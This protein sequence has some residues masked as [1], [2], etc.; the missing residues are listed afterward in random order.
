MQEEN[1]IDTEISAIV[2]KPKTLEKIVNALLSNSFAMHDIHIQETPEE[3][4]KVVG[5]KY[6]DPKQLKKIPLAEVHQ[7]LPYLSDD[8]G[9]VLGFCVAIPMFI[10]MVVMLVLFFDM[11][12][13]LTNFFYALIGAAIG[14]IPGIII[15]KLVKNSRQ[16][17]QKKRKLL[18]GTVIWVHTRTQTQTEQAL[19]VL[20]QYRAKKISQR[21][22]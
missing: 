8:F 12:S 13:I 11:N 3:L 19:A 18:G 2:K 15:A 9:W 17:L 14:I 1:T 22:L 6:P 16:D 4:K 7:D 20:K 10:G 21:K 5:E